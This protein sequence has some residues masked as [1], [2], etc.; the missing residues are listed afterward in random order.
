MPD[1]PMFSCDACGK[2]YAW[3]PAIA[4]KKAKCKCGS[5]LE[6]P[7][8]EPEGNLDDLYAL[9]PEGPVN[10]GHIARVAMPAPV[11]APSPGRGVGGAAVG[12]QRGPTAREKELSATAKYVD[13][14]RDIYTP[15]GLLIAGVL[16]YLA[17]YMIRYEARGGAIAG[18]LLGISIMTVFKT[19]L[20]IGFAFIIA[21]PT[22]VSFGG[23]GT[24]ILKLAAIAIF[25]DGCQ[26]WVDYGVE[27]MAGG[28]GFFNGWLSFPVVIAIYWG[29]MIYLFS[30]D[31]GDAWLVV[32]LLAV[33][34]MIVR[35]V[36]LFLFIAWI[37]SMA[38][39]GSSG[40]L[41][42]G[43]GGGSSSG[44]MISETTEHFNELKDHK[45]IHE[46]AQYIAEGRQGALKDSVQA[47]YDAGAV[48]VY[49]AVDR[50]INGK[51]EPSELVVEMPADKNK[52]KAIYDAINKYY[53]DLKIGDT[54]TDTGE[55]YEFIGIL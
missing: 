44:S 32:I 3:K 20:M 29:L 9:A 7:A 40:T 55:K 37:M 42:G 1:G 17:F 39:A 16:A 11:A 8:D 25:A 36:L 47:W 23:V 21:G 2:S 13:P 49:F 43:S 38:G 48:K 33:F 46:A 10:E 19:I 51:E 18:V 26:T 30:M 15:V 41:G 22:G 24:A 52:R 14:V 4:G 50:D 53:T 27:K 34:D 12:Y 35:W 28:G 5:V 45:L 6:V 54:A 31:G